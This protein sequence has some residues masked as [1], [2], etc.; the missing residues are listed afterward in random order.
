MEEI[1]IENIHWLGHASF[2]ITNDKNIFID[3]YE[4][5]TEDTADIILITHNHYDH[6]SAEDIEKIQGPKTVI[7]ATAD[8]AH[9]LSGKVK[10]IKPGDTLKQSGITVEAV[11]AYN[12]RKAFHPKENNWVGYIITVGGKRIYHTGDS[13][14]IPEMS[15]IEADIVLVP[16]GG[17]YTMSAEEAAQVVNLI[18]PEYAVPMHY[19][20]I[21][22]S[23]ADAQRFAN[24]SHVPVKILKKE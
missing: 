4:L 22:G 20:T 19:G 11:P 2:K 18:K 17:T 9:Q 24:L 21:I 14:A 12:P 13:D 3:P 7:I 23:D 5:Q 1:M 8:C 16:V 6:C 10:T 15:S